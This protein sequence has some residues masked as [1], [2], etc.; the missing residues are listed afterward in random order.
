[1]M[2]LTHADGEH[3]VLH[4]L[5]GSGPPLLLTHGNG[6][7]AGMWATVVPHLQQSFRCWGLDFRGHGASRQQHD[8]MSVDRSRLAGE[9]LAAVNALGGEPLVA[10]GHSLGAACLVLAELQQPGTFRGLYLYEPVLVPDGSPVLET[11]HELVVAARRRR[12][13]FATVDEAHDRF[14]SKPPFSQCEPAAVRA[15]VELGTYPSGDDAVRLSCSGDTEARIFESGG[16]V[17]YR[18]FGA[19]SCPTVVA[20][21]D[22][23][24]M[25]NSG[26]PQLAAPIAEA[27]GNGRLEAF[28]E[29]SH[30]GPM[31]QG[32]LV[33]A[34]IRAHLA[35]PVAA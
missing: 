9:I 11:D 23:P 31:E 13:R 30:F 28:A 2:R 5:G 14:V 26:P 12:L 8:Q 18:L 27:L 34:S 6:L 19:V 3:A 15:Y 7:N 20:R 16:P 22:S 21:G 17:D 32:E 10:A 33:A 1:M 4:D 24:A 29:L 25:W 35:P